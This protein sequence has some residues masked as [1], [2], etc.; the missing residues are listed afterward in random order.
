MTTRARVRLDPSL[1]AATAGA[2]ELTTSPHPKRAAAEGVGGPP[3]S[4]RARFQPIPASL[5]HEFIATA[6]YFKAEARHFEPGHALEDW[7][8]AEADFEELIE[9]RY[10]RP[11]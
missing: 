4:L 7:L 11:A 3:R 8:A 10:G 5:R 9:R 1:E 2:R 6:A